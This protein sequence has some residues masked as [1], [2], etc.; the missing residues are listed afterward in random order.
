[1]FQSQVQKFFRF[2]VRLKTLTFSPVSYDHL[3]PSVEETHTHSCI[4]DAG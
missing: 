1:M 2:D 3:L 4:S